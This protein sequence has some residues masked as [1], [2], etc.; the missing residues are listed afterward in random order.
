MM[1]N[2]ST[3]SPTTDLG[4]GDVEILGVCSFLRYLHAHRSGGI[5]ETACHIKKKIFSFHP[6]QGK[7]KE[8]PSHKRQDW[9]ISP[10]RTYSTAQE[11][12]IRQSTQRSKLRKTKQNRLQVLCLCNTTQW[13]QLLV[14]D[15]LSVD[16]LNYFLFGLYFVLCCSDNDL[17]FCFDFPIVVVIIKVLLDSRHLYYYQRLLLLPRL[18]RRKRYSKPSIR[19]ML[20]LQLIVWMTQSIMRLCRRHLRRRHSRGRRRRKCYS[21]VSIRWMMP[22]TFATTRYLLLLQVM[23]DHLTPWIFGQQEQAM[24]SFFF[25][26]S[27]GCVYMPRLFTTSTSSF[28]VSHHHSPKNIS[29]YTLKY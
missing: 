1:E 8:A 9:T 25:F 7:R 3:S 12:I 15:S 20:L 19:W 16:M 29:K 27:C 14:R 5:P 2:F 11:G 24:A 4:R 28:A 18:Q 22:L 10:P 26:F 23:I 17:Q 21:N 13:I 6:N